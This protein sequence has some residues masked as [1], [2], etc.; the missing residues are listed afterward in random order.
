[1]TNWQKFTNILT[2]IF[3]SLFGL[4]ILTMGE[5]AYLL[6]I[7]VLAI[8]LFVYS[9]RMLVYYFKM[10]RFMVGGKE[11]LI[12]GIL[13][14]DLFIF[15]GSLSTVPTTY[16]LL[17][18]VGMLAFSGVVD[19]MNAMDLKKMQGQWKLQILRGAI[20]VIGAIVCIVK[21]NTPSTV[22]AIFCFMLFYNA[23]MRI[24]NAVRPSEIISIQ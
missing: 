4:L 17:Y 3:M 14:L 22:V 11:I 7:V 24:I 16:V 1:M 19:I 21:M 10:A 2:A 6:I 5:Q 9:I 20:C 12:R 15:I 18:M 8:A 13:F 23:M